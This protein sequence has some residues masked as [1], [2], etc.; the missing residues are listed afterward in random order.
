MLGGGSGLDSL[1]GHMGHMGRPDHMGV[2]ISR[3]DGQDHMGHM[4]GMEALEGHDPGPF[5]HIMAA[6]AA[7]GLY[8]AVAAGPYAAAAA[9]PSGLRRQN[10]NLLGG[11]ASE[12]EDRVCRSVYSWWLEI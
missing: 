5:P 11:G 3:M 10:S 1:E 7:A 6:A 12:D 8:A 2:H 9:G 4:E